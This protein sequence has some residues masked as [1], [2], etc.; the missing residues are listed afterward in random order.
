[1]CEKEGEREKDEG[2]ERQRKADGITGRHWVKA[3]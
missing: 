3:R 1:M 2:T